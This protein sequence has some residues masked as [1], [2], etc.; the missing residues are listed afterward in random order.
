VA[1]VLK[2]YFRHTAKS[3]PKSKLRGEAMLGE[4]SSTTSGKEAASQLELKKKFSS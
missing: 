3:L 1:K 4:Q 2:E